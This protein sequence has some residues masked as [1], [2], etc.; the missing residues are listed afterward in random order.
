MAMAGFFLKLRKKKIKQVG[1]NREKE[2]NGSTL[3]SKV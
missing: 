1:A 3:T 2:S